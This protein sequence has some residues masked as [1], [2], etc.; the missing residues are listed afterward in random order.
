MDL[1][2]FRERIS[3]FDRNTK[4]RLEYKVTFTERFPKKFLCSRRINSSINSLA[5]GTICIYMMIADNGLRAN[6]LV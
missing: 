5:V 1:E 4:N 6:P 3:T 2:Y